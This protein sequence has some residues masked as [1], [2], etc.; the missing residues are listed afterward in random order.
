MP[1]ISRT[2]AAVMNNRVAHES[3]LE[4]QMRAFRCHH[5]NLNKSGYL[6]GHR[7]GPLLPLHCTPKVALRGRRPPVS[8]LEFSEYGMGLNILHVSLSKRWVVHMNKTYNN[9]CTCAWCSFNKIQNDFFHVWMS[10]S[11]RSVPYVRVGGE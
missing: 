11:S 8:K 1:A 9:S 3:H 10:Y 4:T 6:C 7:T 5:E 2:R